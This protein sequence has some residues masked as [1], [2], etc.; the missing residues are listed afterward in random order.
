MEHFVKS[1]SFMI[2]GVA[3][4]LVRTCLSNVVSPIAIRLGG[5]AGLVGIVA[6]RS[7][8]TNPIANWAERPMA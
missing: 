6:G 4:G 2:G 3:D 7:A 1:P 5:A 8:A